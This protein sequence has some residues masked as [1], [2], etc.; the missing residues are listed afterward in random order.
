MKRIL[1][2][3]D[4]P[5][6]G[7]T[8]EPIAPPQS[9]GSEGSANLVDG[10]LSD[11]EKG[12]SA[13][14]PSQP[15]EPVA[16]PTAPKTPEPAPVAAP[17]AKASPTPTPPAKP[18]ATAPANFDDPK[19]TASDLRKHL[20]EMHQNFKMT[21][22]EKERSLGQVNS[23][24]ADLEKKKYWTDDDKKK[25]DDLTQGRAELEARLYAR[26]YSDSPEYKKLFVEKINEQSAEAVEVIGSLTVKYEADG[27]EKTRPGTGQ[28][29]LRLFHAPN[30]ADRRKLAKE[31]F[32]EEFQEAL[33]V[34]KPM[35][36]TRKAA[37][38]AV[39]LKQENFQS[40][41]TMQTEQV[42]LLNRQIQE[43]AIGATGQLAASKPEIFGEP[44][45]PVEAE[46][47]KKGFAFVDES[48]KLAHTFNPN[49]RAARVALIRSMSGAFP[50]VVHLYEKA[51]GELAAANE[52]LAKYRR[53]DPGSAG[54]GGGSGGTSKEAGGTDSMVAEFSKLEQQA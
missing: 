34:V 44:T 2:A 17:A 10:L 40:E 39:K 51:K 5:A 53:S 18:A 20:K 29:M 4:A 38:D 19:L 49:Q 33:D 8:P 23:K 21:L 11:L 14:E 36:E 28:D 3:P 9:G 32:G 25:F 52:E 16:A 13:P 42:Q 37:A 6:G 31:L 43:F 30:L 45:N 50:R 48:S 26:D 7:G 46:I 35:L 12:P 41:T 15:S 47:F 1:L 24:L 54:D 22:E 27:E